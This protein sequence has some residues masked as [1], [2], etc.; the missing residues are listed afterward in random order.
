[1]QVVAVGFGTQRG[2][3][4][5]AAPQVHDQ[6]VGGARA[7]LR[8]G[9]LQ[10][11]GVGGARLEAV[12]VSVRNR[13]AFERQAQH[14]V[15]VGF[16]VGVEGEAVTV[17]LGMQ[18]GDDLQREVTQ[19]AGLLGAAL[20]RPG[21]VNVELRLVGHHRF[22]GRQGERAGESGGSDGVGEALR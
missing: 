3:L 19:Q 13:V 15:N 22:H 4:F 21:G 9:D 18:A 5:E 1:M 2:H 20:A 14:G 8:A 7:D 17:E 11:D 16:T 6:A 10:A 12:V